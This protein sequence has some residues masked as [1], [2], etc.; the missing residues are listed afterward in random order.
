[1]ELET[2]LRRWSDRIGLKREIGRDLTYASIKLKEQ[3]AIIEAQRSIIRTQIREMDD[4]RDELAR[5][6]GEG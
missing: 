6:K 4:L 2:R 1:M 5:E 3:R